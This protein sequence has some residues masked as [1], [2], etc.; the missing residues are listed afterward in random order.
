MDAARGEK[1]AIRRIGRR[2]QFG[3][4]VLDEPS[5]TLLVDGRRVAIEAKPL[6]LLH[7]LLLRAGQVV[8]KDELLDAVWPGISVVEASL[9]TAML[10]LR[11]ALGD[12]KGSGRMVETVPRIGYRLAVPVDMAMVDASSAADTRASLPAGQDS[13]PFAAAPLPTA[14]AAPT[15]TRTPGRAAMPKRRRLL[16]AA[17]LAL[18]VVAGVVAT[19]QLLPAS[20][21]R[22][23]HQFTKHDITNA[24]R[25]LDLEKIEMMLAA[26]WDPNTAF[27]WQGDGAINMVLA[28]CEWD[29]QHDKQKLLLVVRT[30]LDGGARLDNRNSFGDTAYSIAAAPRYCGPDHP[31]TVMLHTLCYAGLNPAGDKCLPTYANSER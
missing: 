11:R 26:G 17:S 23:T 3:P 2:W 14:N 28:V 7:E 24:L 30:L 10:K 12:E 25:K 9:P 22:R 13:E 4:A 15:D 21:D 16:I 27:N 29:K 6:D 5:W 8:T 1:A 18:L 19:S 20:P 31:V